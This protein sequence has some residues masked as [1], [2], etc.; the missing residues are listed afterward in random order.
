MTTIGESAKYVRS[1]GAGPFW[2]TIDIFCGS[3]EKFDLFRQSNAICPKTFG[4]IF[5]VPEE[6]VKIFFLSQLNVIKISVPRIP[7]QGHREERDMHCGQQYI[8]I[9]DV[10]L[11]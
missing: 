7:P 6:N 5:R 2:M 8:R 10:A 4:D 1:K 11:S 3:E 9:L